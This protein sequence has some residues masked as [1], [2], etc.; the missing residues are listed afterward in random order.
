MLVKETKTDSDP[1]ER[2]VTRIEAGE[3]NAE[4][5]LVTKY[6]RGLYFI[7]NKRARD[8]ELA[9]DI[10]QDTFLLVLEKARSGAINKPD[11]IASFIRQTGVNLLIANYRKEKRRKTEATSDIHIKFPGLNTDSADR[12]HFKKLTAIVKQVIDELPTARD[13]EIL[14]QHFL[15]HCDKN[16][17][18][19]SLDLTPE[20]FDR[21]LFRAR[22]RLK[23]LL[24]HRLKINICEQSISHLFSIG[25]FILGFYTISTP[26]AVQPD[27][28]ISNQVR[29]L[30]STHHYKDKPH[31]KLNINLRRLMQFRSEAGNRFL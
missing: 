2:I 13:R 5:E 4:Q 6:W 9:A 7:L 21:V 14:K 23:K 28:S 12:I 31:L 17:V 16:I 22:D 25:L 3:R 15:Y 18:C 11:A 26:L 8:P 30:T 10:T 29:D 1:A 24:S 19:D 20:H 27:E